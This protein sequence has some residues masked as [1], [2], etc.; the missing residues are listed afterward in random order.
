MRK[1]LMLTVVFG[2]FGCE[3]FN[4]V[5]E[6]S[7]PCTILLVNG[8]SIST[9]ETIKIMESTNIITYRDADGKLWSIPPAEYSSYSCGL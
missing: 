7:G 3:G 2:M 1:Y 5:T 4:D 9:Q 8:A 6:T